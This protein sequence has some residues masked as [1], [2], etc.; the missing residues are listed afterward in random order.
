MPHI[1]F[2]LHSSPEQYKYILVILWFLVIL[3]QLHLILLFYYFITHV[4]ISSFVYQFLNRLL[5]KTI[6]LI[7]FHLLLVILSK[8][9]K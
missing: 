1:P 6:R 3:Q 4:A 5:S 9:L 7:L 2:L 8:I